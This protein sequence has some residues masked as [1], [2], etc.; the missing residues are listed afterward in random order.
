MIWLAASIAVVYFLSHKY[1]NKKIIVVSND[2]YREQMA[3]DSAKGYSTSKMPASDE[4]PSANN[5]YEF[6]T[7]EPNNPDWGFRQTGPN[8]DLSYLD[9]YANFGR[10][11]HAAPII[12]PAHNS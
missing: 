8:F 9:D 6:S 4:L 1:A 7:N 12:S 3:T 11:I 2:E 5:V 10:R